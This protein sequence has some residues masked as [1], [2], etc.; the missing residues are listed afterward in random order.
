MDDPRKR[1]RLGSGGTGAQRL[2]R[3][4][5]STTWVSPSRPRRWDDGH[6]VESGTSPLWV[7]AQVTIFSLFDFL[8]PGPPARLTTS[9]A[10][11]RGKN[12]TAPPRLPGRRRAG[13]PTRSRSAGEAPSR[14]R[15]RAVARSASPNAPTRPHAIPNRATRKPTYS[16][17]ACR[18]RA[19]IFR[20]RVSRGRPLR[21]R[22]LG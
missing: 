6:E 5:A 18:A 4:R 7:W 10:R 15:S 13:M 16:A 2:A 21:G 11:P 22:L 9:R 1:P 8:G 12:F 20:H 17:T 19:S 14:R 3:M